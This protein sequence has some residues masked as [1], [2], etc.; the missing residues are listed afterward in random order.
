MLN[1]LWILVLVGLVIILIA[2]SVLMVIRKSK[3]EKLN[4]VFAMNTVTVL[5]ILT[6]GFVRGRVDLFIVIA[7]IY[8][9][10]I[11]ATSV[12]LLKKT[13]GRKK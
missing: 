11:S 13:G 1:N 3:A 4:C 12:I 9:V 7:L 10:L 8:S 6:L 5:L 2:M